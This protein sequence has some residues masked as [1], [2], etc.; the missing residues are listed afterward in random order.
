MKVDASAELTTIR[1][2]G[3]LWWSSGKE[4]T[5]SMQGTRFHSRSGNQDPTCHGAAKPMHHGY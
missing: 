5:L 1:L 3:L 4:S 2:W